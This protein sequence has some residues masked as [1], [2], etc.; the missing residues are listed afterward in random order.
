MRNRFGAAY[1]VALPSLERAMMA[2]EF[3]RLDGKK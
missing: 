3:H 2:V 1:S